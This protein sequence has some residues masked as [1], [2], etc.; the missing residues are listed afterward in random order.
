[1]DAWDQTQSLENA[2][3]EEGTSSHSDG[4]YYFTAIKT[5]SIITLTQ[6]REANLWLSYFF[7][8]TDN[9]SGYTNE[10]DPFFILPPLVVDQ[11]HKPRVL[12]EMVATD[13]VAEKLSSTLSWVKNTVSHT[14]SQMASQVASPSASLHTTSSSTT[15]STPALSPASPSKLSP[16]DLELLAKLE[17]QNRLLNPKFIDYLA[18]KFRDLP[19]SILPFPPST[20]VADIGPMPSFDT[21]LSNLRH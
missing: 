3:P 21:D 1:M 20:G 2:K 10:N 15:L 13:K 4:C 8:N 14:V 7:W 5:V 18:R 12:H 9:L 16:D 6:C 19:V 17:E 11:L